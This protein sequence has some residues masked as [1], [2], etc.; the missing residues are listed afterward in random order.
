M[1]AVTVRDVDRRYVLAVRR[2]PVHD[3]IARSAPN[4]ASTRS[5]KLRRGCGG[6]KTQIAE[7]QRCALLLLVVVIL[8]HHTRAIPF[9]EDAPTQGGG[10][11]GNADE[12][13]CPR[14]MHFAGNV[15]GNLVHSNLYDQTADFGHHV[16]RV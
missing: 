12:L 10:S 8:V 11:A 2:D 9:P 16:N 6:I 14:G 13:D 7:R 3:P 15:S 5:A 4:A 1:V